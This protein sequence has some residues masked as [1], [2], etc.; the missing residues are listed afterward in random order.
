MEAPNQPK[1][2][3]IEKSPNP[4]GTV[5]L[6]HHHKKGFFNKMGRF[7]KS[8]WKVAKTPTPAIKEDK[9]VQ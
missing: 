6:E 4:D 9:K 3:I 7:F 8:A 1:I 5:G 2:Q